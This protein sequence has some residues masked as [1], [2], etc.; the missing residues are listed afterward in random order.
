MK[1]ERLKK[2]LLRIFWTKGCATFPARKQYNDR[3]DQNVK[4]LI[5]PPNGGQIWRLFA[6]EPNTVINQRSVL[7][8]S[9]MSHVL[10]SIMLL[11]RFSLSARWLGTFFL[12]HGKGPTSFLSSK[13]W[14]PVGR[15]Q[16]LFRNIRQYDRESF[17]D[18]PGGISR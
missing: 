10:F 17:A 2:I 18:L 12:L 13:Y 1:W 5:L 11:V 14:S 9:D 16:D 4:L 8:R 15:R 7:N 3:D 6:P